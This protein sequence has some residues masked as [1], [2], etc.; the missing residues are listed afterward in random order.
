[1]DNDSVFA[2]SEDVVSA[3]R[4]INEEM[5]TPAELKT[6]EDLKTPDF[7][8]DDAAKDILKT[9]DNNLTS[10]EKVNEESDILTANTEPVNET[11]LTEKKSSLNQSG[12]N[13]T[14]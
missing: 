1:L 13:N 6:P 14:R 10:N 7:V 2:Q 3:S 11:T 5:N 12:N 9:P 4:P 8:S